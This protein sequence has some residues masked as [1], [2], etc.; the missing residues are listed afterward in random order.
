MI[1][2]LGFILLDLIFSQLSGSLREVSYGHLPAILSG[3]I[4]FLLLLLNP[5]YF[6][7]SDDHEFIHIQS[8]SALWPVFED[9]AAI[10]FNIP[11]SYI[12]NYRIAGRGFRPNLTLELSIPYRGESQY[13]FKMSFMTT[14]QLNL[15]HNSLKRVLK[16]IPKNRRSDLANAG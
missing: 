14:S 6:S 12:K 5:R 2:L 4:L 10:N 11:K 1:V 8:H 3:V 9:R 16:S 15:I 13:C 7:F